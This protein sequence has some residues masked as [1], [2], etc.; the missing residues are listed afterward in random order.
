MNKSGLLKVAAA[1]ATTAGLVSSLV[2]PSHVLGSSHREAPL[3]SADPQADLTDLY[4]FVSPDRPDTVTLIMSVNPFESAYGG[5][6][7]HSFGDDVLYEFKVD[8]NGDALPDVT[9][10][11]EFK[12]TVQNPNTFLYNVGPI[13]SLTDSN[14]NVR[15]TYTLRKVVGGTTTVLGTDLPVPPVNIGKKSTPN[16]PALASAA[17]RSLPGG[18]LSFAG[19]TDDAFF[20]DLGAIF[21]LLTIRKLPGNKGGGVDGLAG[22]NVHS[23]ALQLPISEVT[24]TGT[25]ITDPKADGAVVGVWATASRKATRVLSAGSSSSSGEWIQ[26]SRLGHPLVNE[27][28]IPRGM[29]DKFN[30]SKPADDA[31]FA[32]HVTDPELAKL[33]NA[34]YGIKVPPQAPFGDPKGRDDLVAIFLTGLKDLTQPVGVKPSEQ[35]RLN[36]AVAPASKP[37]SL[38]VAGGDT[39]GF[40][41]GRRLADDVTDIA[42]KAV[43]GALY[44]LFHPEFT[45]DPLAAQLGDGVDANDKAFQASFPYL[46]LAWQGSEA[47]PYGYKKAKERC[48]V[49][50]NAKRGARGDHVV[51]LQ[52]CLHAKGLLKVAPTGFHGALTDEA[53]AKDAKED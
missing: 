8:N 51:A 48:T 35:L 36:V 39:A 25:R 20:V 23:I 16:Y 38:G 11:Y 3:I 46:A 27:V 12:T 4:A 42:L 26:V 53:I 24:K 32:N 19:Q 37:N 13:N 17:V 14:W 5:P 52:A 22:Y 1:A 10:Q 49:P 30:S 18:G 43:A 45:P 29:K 33:F 21:D 6:N 28:V 7:Y 50:A 40:P 2:L 34:L 9:Y 31:Q 41:N 44:P 47:Y 15:Q